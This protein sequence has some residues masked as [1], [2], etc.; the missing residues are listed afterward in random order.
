MRVLIIE[1]EAPAYRRL[2]TLISQNHHDLDVV[3]VIDSVQD[4]IKWLRNHETPN[5]IFSDIQLADGLS[6]E[7]YREEPV[8]CP[9]IFTTAYDEYMMDAFRTNGID[10]LLKPIEQKDLDRSISKFRDLTG[11][12]TKENPGIEAVLDLLDQRQ[13]KYKT[14]FLIK[15]GSKLLPLQ[16][17]EIA[18][19]F[20]SDG[21]TH[22]V[23]NANRKFL[24]DQTLDELE[25]VLNPQI[26]YRSNRQFLV[27]V[28]S[29]QALH[30]YFKGKLKLDLNPK[31]DEDVIVSREK[32]RSFKD[33]LDERS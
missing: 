21:F 14:R 28:Q 4:A 12:Q 16:V 25:Q 20:S 15:V 9:I 22:I 2:N 31:P 8:K 27:H 17:S 13:K 24:A 7:I 33:W 26:F 18:Y 11:A 29:I 3:E 30:Q 1:D 10:Y 32:A 23:T 6:F 5:L 19:F